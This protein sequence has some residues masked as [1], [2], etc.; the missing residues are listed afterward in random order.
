[1]QSTYLLEGVLIT[2]IMQLE[3][4]AADFFAGIGLV[5][6]GLVKQGWEVKYAIDHSEAK[7]RM[8]EANF[9]SGHY[10][11]K[12]IED[13]KGEELPKVTLAHASFPCTDTSIAGARRGM[14]SGESST[15]W[16]FARIVG[17]MGSENGLGKPPFLLI[18]NVEGFLTSG[19]S[20]DLVAAIE[21]L[22]SL[23]Y[24]VDMLLINA[25]RF[26]PQ[27]RVRLFLIGVLGELGQSAETVE[28]KLDQSTDA[29]PNKIKT[30][31]RKNPHLI[32]H[33]RDLPDLPVNSLKLKDIID[34]RAEWWPRGRADYLFSQMF[35]RH[36]EEVRRLMQNQHWSYRTVFRRMRVRDGSKQS[37]AEVR[38][39]GIAGCLRT[40]KGGSGRQIVIRVGKGQ[41]DARLLNA[42][43][44][45][46]LMGANDYKLDEQ[47]SLNDALFGFGDAV[48]VSVIQWI[49]ENYLEPLVKSYQ[50]VTQ[51]HHGQGKMIEALSC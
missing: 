12:K 20:Q 33:L 38:T 49:A 2:S 30:F 25:A 29:R 27:S 6:L 43:E 44:T 21:A 18:E 24:A 36:R 46:R 1:M 15:F 19:E 32:W 22:N 42:R 4:T 11:V 5:S 3:K 40:P 41:Y 9:R 17:E 8:Y 39:D 28:A 14:D 50:A 37:T 23:G 16:E 35:D 45:A 48:C 51:G 13:V 31:I 10:H 34:P 7:Q 47:L 26:V